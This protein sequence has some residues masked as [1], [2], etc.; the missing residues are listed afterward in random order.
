MEILGLDVGGS[1]IKG[2]IIDTD[3]GELIS[4]RYRLDTPQPS[5]PV[6][7]AETVSKI[8]DHFEWKGIVGCSFPAVI[9][10]GKS[11]TAGNISKKWIGTQAD[12]LFSEHCGGLKFYLAN[13]ADLAGVAEMKLG[14]G[15]GLV[16]KVMMIT[17]GTG[18]GTGM[19]YNGQLIPNMEL[20]R[21]LYK[22]GEPVEYFAADSARKKEGLSMKEWARRFDYYLHHMVRICSP[23]YFILGG[24]ISKKYDKFKDYLTVDTP[25]RVAEARNE[26]GIIGA[27]IHAETLHA[28]VQAG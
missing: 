11:M 17:V 16:G 6:R 7:V 23:D 9:I 18:L 20:G 15:R 10:K 1:G 24:G 14:A 3:K 19:F 28:Q 4:E 5:K 8:V 26:A 13:D 25:I 21:I 2:A 22:D 27:A 12:A